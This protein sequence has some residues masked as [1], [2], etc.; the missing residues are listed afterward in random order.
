[1]RATIELPDS[2]FRRAKAIA[3]LRGTTLREL[4]TRAVER[5]TQAVD[6][7]LLQGGTPVQL[8]LVP[9]RRPGATKLTADRVAQLLQAE[10]L[11]DVPARR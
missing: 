5:D 10:D 7:R 6:L 3:S 9:S 11:A 2:L 1:M 8:P 4:V